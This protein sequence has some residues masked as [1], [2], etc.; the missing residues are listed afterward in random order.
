MCG[1]AVFSSFFQQFSELSLVFHQTTKE[2]E[3][4][5]EKTFKK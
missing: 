3:V 1:V 4:V 2:D 5:E